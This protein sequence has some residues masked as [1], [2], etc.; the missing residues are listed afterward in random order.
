MIKINLISLQSR[1]GRK[2]GRVFSSQTV[3]LFGLALIVLSILGI[4]SVSVHRQ[5]NIL[6][7]EKNVMRRELAGLKQQSQQTEKL[8]KT[9]AD[10]LARIR[11]LENRPERKFW[12]V[13]LMDLIS[14]SLNPLSLWLLHVLMDGRKVE[15]EGRG[16]KSE[17][18]QKFVNTLEQSAVW[19]NLEAIEMQKESY[20]DLPVYHFNL[21]FTMTG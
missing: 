8:E 2:Q 5:Y 1:L 6:L 18:I 19:E 16:L 20:E 12:P 17:E 15:I 10:L 7:N 4:W 9:H 11:L 21:R 14:R 3:L 13:R